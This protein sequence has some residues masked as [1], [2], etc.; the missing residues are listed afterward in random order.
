MAQQSGL[1]RET[2]SAYVDG[3]LTAEEMSRVAS[4]IERDGQARAYVE[5]QMR[6]RSTLRNAFS[7]VSRAEVPQA[8]R[9]KAASSPVSWRFRL[10]AW[11]E[12][13]P[14]ALQAGIPAGA[15]AA[16][17]MIG[18]AVERI[19]SA[20]NLVA[21]SASTGKVVARAEL[22]S[23]LQHML[24]A[25][26]QQGGVRIGVSFRSRTGTP[27]RTFNIAAGAS[28]LDGLACRN[29]GEWQ[30]AVLN[31]VPSSGASEPQYGQ[32]ASEMSDA[33]RHA[34]SA[35]I[36]GLPFDMSQER[37]ARDRGWN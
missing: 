13:I 1:T 36:V 23:A 19:G 10:A 37:Q 18:I 30:I 27:C 8:L 6:L 20:D 9:E 35:A 26:A 15:L 34:V 5:A 11:I 7:A 22:A 4:A 33:V 17:L 12:R 3:E 24:A 2:L 28:S 14:V 29:N 32:A 31:A 25:E 16:G 21:V